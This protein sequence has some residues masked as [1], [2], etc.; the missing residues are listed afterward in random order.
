M[1]AVEGTKDVTVARRSAMLWPLAMSTWNS[2]GTHRYYCETDLLFVEL[3]GDMGLDDVRRLW[4]IAESIEQACGYVITVF[5]A[6]DSK[7]V[8]PEARRYV[9]EKNR[10]R[11]LV[12]PVLVVGAG[13]AMRTITL[14]LQQAARVFGK[15]PASVHFCAMMEGLP[16]LLAAQ[17]QAFAPSLSR[18]H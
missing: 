4:P 13:F 14:L 12:G 2:L 18:Q 15:R 10:K 9:G 3:H 5:D 11:T 17:R 8:N 16:P 7:S 6:R 1:D